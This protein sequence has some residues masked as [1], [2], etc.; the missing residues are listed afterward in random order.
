MVSSKKR[1]VVEVVE[2][3][4]VLRQHRL[5]ARGPGR[6]WPSVWPPTASTR[7]PRHRQRRWASGTKPRARRSGARPPAITRTTESSARVWMARSCSRKPS[8]SGAQPRRARRRRPWRWARRC[9]CRWS[10]PAAAG[11]RPAAGAAAGVGGRKSPTSCQRR[12][13]PRRQRRRPAAAAQSTMG[14][15]GDGSAARAGRVELG[16]AASSGGQVAGHHRQR[17]V[18]PAACAG[19]A[20]PPRRPGV[21]SAAS[22]K[23][24]SALDRH[25]APGGRAAASGR[26]QRRGAARGGAAPGATKVELR[27][28]RRAGVGLGVKAAVAGVAVLAR[29]A[30]GT[31]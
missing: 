20:R 9:G 30:P 27:A 10:S 6:R 29:A 14:R 26:R 19:A 11:P 4:Q 23:P 13:P 24:P 15:A 7:R 17:L 25:D 2:L 18:R 1:K 12:A 22:T 8:A 31:A 3:A 5:A 16:H 28:A 21:A